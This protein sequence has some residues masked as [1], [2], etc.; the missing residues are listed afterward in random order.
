MGCGIGHS[1][2]SA[3]AAAC[4]KRCT[5]MGDEE[6]LLMSNCEIYRMLDLAK[7]RGGEGPQVNV[8]GKLERMGDDEAITID[9]VEAANPSDSA[10]R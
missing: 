5:A 7:L 6:L 3:E 9:S 4:V 8:N 10:S 2:P 1:K